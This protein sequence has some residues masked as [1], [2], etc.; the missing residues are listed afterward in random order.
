MS[1]YENLAVSMIPDAVIAAL[2]FAS[3]IYLSRKVN[4][5]GVIKTERRAP[6]MPSSFFSKTAGKISV[7]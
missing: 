1:D 3:K 5:S 6:Q 4:E 7:S 2:S